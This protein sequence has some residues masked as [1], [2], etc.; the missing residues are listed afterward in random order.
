[1]SHLISDNL[2]TNITWG[3]VLEDKAE[4]IVFRVYGQH[5]NGLPL[6][7]CGGQF[8]S[9]C[10]VI[11]ETQA[12]VMCG[13]EHQLDSGQ[14]QAKSIIYQTSQQHWQRSRTLIGTTNVPFCSIHKPGGTF[15][16]TAGNVTS[17][18][19]SQMS[20]SMVDG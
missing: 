2:V 5:V 1:M 17:R 20:D 14:H 16:V 15:I 19:K 11:K 6:A 12:G 10:K 13:H 7:R 18:I 9:V 8:D 4:S 3:N